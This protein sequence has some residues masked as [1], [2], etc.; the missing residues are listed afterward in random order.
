MATASTPVPPSFAILLASGAPPAVPEL[1]VNDAV[2]AP[3]ATLISEVELETLVTV[4]P[5]PVA[6]IV[7]VPLP[8]VIVIPEP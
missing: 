5:P 2:V 1:R 3:V 8:L 7:I 6:A 4:P